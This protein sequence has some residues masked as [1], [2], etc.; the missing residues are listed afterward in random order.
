VN[1]MTLSVVLAILISGVAL[2]L[3]FRFREET[4]TADA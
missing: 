4:Q 1:L 2:C 3:T